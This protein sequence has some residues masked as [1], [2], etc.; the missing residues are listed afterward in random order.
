[1]A[2]TYHFYLA[3]G[4]HDPD[5]DYTKTYVNLG[6]AINAFKKAVA[7]GYEY[8]CLELLRDREESKSEDC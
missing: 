3:T 4:K 1:M 6:A 7:D 2:D 5:K 8:A